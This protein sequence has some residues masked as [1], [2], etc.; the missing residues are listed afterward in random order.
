MTNSALGMIGLG[1]MGAPMAHHL[2]AKHGTLTITGRRP[3]PELVNSGATWVNTA[4]E[5][6]ANVDA[7]LLMLPDLPQLEEVL[8]GEQGLL[9]GVRDTGLLLMIGSTSSAT[10]VREL[11][12]RL[13]TESNGLVRVVDCPVSGGE[14]GANAGTLSV[15]VGGEK[16]DADL[17]ATLL[18]PCG[19]P[20]HLGPLG[21]GQVAKACNQMVVSA[22][23]LALGEATVLAD[24]SGIDL[25][26]MWDLLSGG[27]AGSRL[28]DSRKDKLVSG[29]D[30]PSGMAKYM[31]KDLAS[32]AEIAEATGTNT[33]LLPTLRAAFDEIVAS[34]LGDQD[35]AVS[36]RFVA[37]R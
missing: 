20:V 6:A 10:G 3:Q 8:S 36:R 26:K 13:A 19:N 9:A 5:L 7:V 4:R 14:D 12:E 15:M 16:D 31:V 18:A 32:A 2:L 23:I 27:Y 11:A 33:A 1:A 29:D 30:S 37:E 25:E 17:A 34:G 35:I 24:R 22:T 28:L 21:A